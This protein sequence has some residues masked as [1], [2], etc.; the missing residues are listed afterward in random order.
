MVGLISWLIGSRI[1]RWT[2]FVGLSVAGL[3]IAYWMVRRSAYSAVELKQARAQIK[4]LRAA[5]RA[6]N[7][8]TQMSPDQRRYYVRSWLSVDPDK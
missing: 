6:N 3:A 5:L 1:G 4:S 8:I 7:E 2:A